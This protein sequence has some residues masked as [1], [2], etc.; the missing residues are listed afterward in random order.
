VY[1]CVRER[2]L[3]LG[4]AAAVRCTAACAHATLTAAR[5][6][7]ATGRAIGVHCRVLRLPDTV[8]QADLQAVVAEVSADRAIDGVLVQL[9]LPPHLNEEAVMEALDPRKDVDGFHPLNMG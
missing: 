4:S 3:L 5:G 8:Q 7:P 9:P 2:A 1:V 6:A